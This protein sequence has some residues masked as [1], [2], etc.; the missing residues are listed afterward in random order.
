MISVNNTILWSFNRHPIF[1][2]NL[3]PE[4]NDF[5]KPKSIDAIAVSKTQLLP[6]RPSNIHPGRKVKSCAFNI[7][8]IEKWEWHKQSITKPKYWTH[9]SET[10]SCREG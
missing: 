5:L 7:P 4:S 2:S 10:I 3:L 1:H 8:Q 6:L 9:D